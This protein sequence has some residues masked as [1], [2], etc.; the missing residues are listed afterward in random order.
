MIKKNQKKNLKF[1]RK[2]CVN[3]NNNKI[4]NRK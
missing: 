2:K 4:E 1:K 3:Q